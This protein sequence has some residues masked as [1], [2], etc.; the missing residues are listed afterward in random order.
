MP[1]DD[2]F[3]AWAKVLSDL[4]LDFEQYERIN[5]LDNSLAVGRLVLLLHISHPA[6]LHPEYAG[7]PENI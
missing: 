3:D 1:T 2:W 5:R 7:P 6:S 4:R